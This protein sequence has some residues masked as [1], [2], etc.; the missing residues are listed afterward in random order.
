MPRIALERNCGSIFPDFDQVSC[1]QQAWLSWEL[2]S[3]FELSSFPCLQSSCIGLLYLSSS[4]RLSPQIPAWLGSSTPSQP[5][6]SPPLHPELCP[7][8]N[9][10]QHF[11][12]WYPLQSWISLICLLCGGEHWQRSACWLSGQSDFGALLG[13]LPFVGVWDSSVLQGKTA[14]IS[15]RNG[16]QSVRR[17]TSRC[18]QFLCWDLTNCWGLS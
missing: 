16:L 15:I 8:S 2:I 17:G 7:I 11:S 5:A 14:Q 18:R 6:K 4:F 1:L 9:L 12:S 10:Y 13:I 3:H